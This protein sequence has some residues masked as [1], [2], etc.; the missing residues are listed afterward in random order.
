MAAQ[1]WCLTKLPWLG[2]WQPCCVATHLLLFVGAV[3]F[4]QGN[5]RTLEQMAGC[6]FCLEYIRI[7]KCNKKKQ[8][9]IFLFLLSCVNVGFYCCLVM[10]ISY[11]SSFPALKLSISFSQQFSFSVSKGTFGN[12]AKLSLAARDW[13]SQRLGYFWPNSFRCAWGLWI[14]M[15]GSSNYFRK[16]WWCQWRKILPY[17]SSSIAWH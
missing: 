4:K 12:C 16:H 7:R 10:F 5:T 14:H 2:C 3:V 1:A 17:L 6:L 13:F 11:F 8:L 15:N 9:L